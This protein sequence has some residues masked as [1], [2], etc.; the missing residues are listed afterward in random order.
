MV[1]RAITAL[2]DI[3]NPRIAILRD[4]EIAEARRGKHILLW[5]SRSQRA[6]SNHAA[7]VAIQLGNELGLPIVAC[8]CIVPGYPAATLRAY[9]F[10]AEGLEELPDALAKRGIGWVLRVGKPER[11]IPTLATQVGAAVIVTDADPLRTGRAWRQAVAERIKVPMVEVDT[12]TVIPP[13][14]FDKE[15]WAPRTIRPKVMR[16][17]PD[18]LVPIP[19]PSAAIPS[20]IRDGP[21]PVRL[22]ET[23]PLDRRVEPSHRFRGGARQAQQALARFLKSRLEMYD[24][25]RDTTPLGGTSELSPYLHFGQI[26]PTEVAVA[27]NEAKEAGVRPEAVDAYLDELVVQRELAINFARHNPNY[28]RFE[29]LPDWG[30]KTLSAHSN[31][32]R[33]KI[34]TREQLEGGDTDDRLW[35][36]AQCQLLVEGWMPN[37]LRMYWAKRFLY[38]THSPEEAYELACEL[39]DRY[40]VDGRD[41]NGYAGIAWAIGGRHDRPFPPEKPIIGL[42][43]PMGAAGLRKHFDVDAYIEQIEQRYGR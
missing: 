8:F 39:N 28:D 4:G 24:K 2:V 22:L 31:D 26:S 10:I 15:E 14:L 25:G 33:P 38:W 20:A 1:T 23:L 13:S 37:R 18:A 9:R 27:V 21:D 43:R 5:L 42:I 36:A 30:R 19:S 7:N 34:F 40:F 32:R 3:E 35:N 6:T 41:T 16:Y 11:I 29:G 17:L 12:D